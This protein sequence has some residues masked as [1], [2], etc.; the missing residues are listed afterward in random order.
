MFDQLFSLHENL[1]EGWIVYL[2]TVIQLGDKQMGVQDETELTDTQVEGGSQN[3][4]HCIMLNLVIGGCTDTHSI[5]MK[6]HMQRG[7]YDPCNRGEIR[8]PPTCAICK[9]DMKKGNMMHLI[10][11]ME[12]NHTDHAKKGCKM[13]KGKAIP[14]EQWV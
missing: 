12:T 1:K 14:T 13:T 6:Q 7:V 11:T 10:T 9:T 3:N 4:D 2:I 5:K 8:G